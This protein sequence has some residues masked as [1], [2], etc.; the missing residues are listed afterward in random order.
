[1]IPPGLRAAGLLLLRSIVLALTEPSLLH[2]LFPVAP[3]PLGHL[4]SVVGCGFLRRAGTVTAVSGTPLILGG[5]IVP[6]V[7]PGSGGSATPTGPVICWCGEGV[8]VSVIIIVI[9]TARS[10]CTRAR[11][12]P[13]VG[14]G[15]ILV[16]GRSTG[17]VRGE[18][19][20]ISVLF[21]SQNLNL[22]VRGEVN[23]RIFSR[24]R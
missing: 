13:S 21:S 16:V 3:L 10:G 23:Q 5:I 12:S 17:H 1:M 24:G 18:D 15:I 2:L 6:P 22:V 8:G 7:F 19:L 4:F 9:V 20:I 14:H 11:R